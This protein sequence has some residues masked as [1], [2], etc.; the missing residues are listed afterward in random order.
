MPMS[1]HLGCAVT[2]HSKVDGT[3]SWLHIR[4]AGHC[5]VHSTGRVQLADWWVEWNPVYS[6]EAA[7]QEGTAAGQAGWAPGPHSCGWEAQ[8]GCL[9]ILSEVELRLPSQCPFVWGDSTKA[10]H[11]VCVFDQLLQLDSEQGQGVKHKQLGEASEFPGVH[12][13]AGRP[14]S[15]PG[16]V[17]LSY[18]PCTGRQDPRHFGLWPHLLFSIQVPV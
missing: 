2:C 5:K 15:F 12:S 17:T 4:L 9:R 11:E 3:S 10:S 16:Q 7:R 6:P 18:S 13:P 14:G 1:P 8:E